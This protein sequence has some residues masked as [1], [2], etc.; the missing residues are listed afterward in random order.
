MSRG[1]R[2]EG[3][4]RE[5]DREGDAGWWLGHGWVTWVMGATVL[6]RLKTTRGPGGKGGGERG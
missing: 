2:G 5:V 4:G 6:R 1:C 3:E